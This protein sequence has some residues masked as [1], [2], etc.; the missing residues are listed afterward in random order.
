MG[1]LRS[2]FSFAAVGSQ[3]IRDKAPLGQD[4]TGRLLAFAPGHLCQHETQLLGMLCFTPHI[5]WRGKVHSKAVLLQ[6][7]QPPPLQNTPHSD[8]RENRE[9]KF[10]KKKKSTALYSGCGL[11]EQGR[12]LADAVFKWIRTF[13]VLRKRYGVL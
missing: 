9:Q 5:R 12:C 6:S 3:G 8:L 2:P 1:R 13:A 10:K 11:E 7:Q 4:L